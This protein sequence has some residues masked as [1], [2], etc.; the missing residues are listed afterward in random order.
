MRVLVA[1]GVFGVWVV[2]G[3][4]C[5]HLL[6]VMT[7]GR[8]L[9]GSTVEPG[10]LG[11]VTELVLS[12]FSLGVWKLVNPEWV[13]TASVLVELGA[14]VGM[15]VGSVSGVMEVVGFGYVGRTVLSLVELGM[16]TI[17]AVEGKTEDGGVG[18]N[19]TFVSGS[20][21]LVVV[22]EVVTTVMVTVSGQG[23]VERRET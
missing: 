10:T 2:G 23:V 8:L 18:V 15:W 1:T 16:V 12:P 4:A 3:V 7:V 13:G 5:V 22:G 17:S 9:L 11:V 19:V 20:T 21:S 14:P 6:E